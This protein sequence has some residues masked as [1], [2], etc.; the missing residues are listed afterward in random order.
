MSK[1]VIKLDDI[2]LPELPE[3]MNEI[4]SDFLSE[5]KFCAASEGRVK[6]GEFPMNHYAL[7]RGNDYKDLG[8]VVHGFIIRMVPKA[9]DVSGDKPVSSFAKGSEAFEDISKRSNEQDSG[10]MWGPEL[11]VWLPKAEEFAIMFLRNKTLRNENE[12]FMATYGKGFT[13]SK[14]LIQCKNFDDYMSAK[15]EIFQG[16]KEALATFTA[17]Q[18]ERAVAKFEAQYAYGVETLADLK[19]ASTPAE[20]EK[21]KRKKR[22]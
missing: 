11:L 12:N 10:C 5:L 6:K 2:Q 19:A 21:P 1:E 13:L 8:E 17:A 18:M 4:G 20:D 9:L 16:E 22:G 7:K 3:A 14:Q 15:C